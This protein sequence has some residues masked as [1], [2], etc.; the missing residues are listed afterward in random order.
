MPAIIINSTRI[1]RGH[2][3]WRR[4]ATRHSISRSKR[5]AIEVDPLTSPVASAGS[6]Q[7]GQDLESLIKAA[8]K[9]NAS[10]R[11]VTAESSAASSAAS[12]QACSR[13]L[14]P[15]NGVALI[16]AFFR[17]SHERMC[18]SSWRTASSSSSSLSTLTAI[19]ETITLGL[20]IPTRIRGG[21]PSEALIVGTILP[22]GLLFADDRHRVTA[23]FVLASAQ[24]IRNKP[25]PRISREHNPRTKVPV[26]SS[27]DL[28]SSSQ[29]DGKVKNTLTPTEKAKGTIRSPNSKLAE[30]DEGF[31]HTRWAPS[32]VSTTSADTRQYPTAK[33]ASETRTPRAAN[34]TS[35]LPS[36]AVRADARL[37]PATGQAFLRRAHRPLP[38]NTKDAAT[39]TETLESV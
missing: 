8:A 2:V 23:R 32:H 6:A 22:A 3:T 31:Q 39:H 29:N 12:R 4:L 20:R 37:E 24:S 27:R 1:V 33:N 36:P 10:R 21:A 11:F 16:K 35:V 7:S 25:A 13:L 15:G 34:V 38:Q 14:I 28:R 30:L 18:A 5:T 17:L 26:S 19:S 9:A